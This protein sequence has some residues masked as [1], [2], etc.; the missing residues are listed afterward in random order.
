MPLAAG[1]QSLEVDLPLLD[2]PTMSF[3]FLKDSLDVL[4]RVLRTGHLLTPIVDESQRCNFPQSGEAATLAAALADA[5]LVL[6]RT[7]VG[8]G[9]AGAGVDQP[10]QP[11]LLRARGAAVPGR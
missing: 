10:L 11:R 6:I 9:T 3:G 4:V 5:I 1:A 7:A 2:L 8:A